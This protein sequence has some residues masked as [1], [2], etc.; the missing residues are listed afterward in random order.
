MFSLKFDHNAKFEDG[1]CDF[2]VL[3]A[4]QATSKS[5]N[6]MIK[7]KVRV[8][9]ERGLSAIVY[10]YLVGTINMQWK[11]EQFCKAVNHPEQWEQDVIT[12][13]FCVGKKG[14]CSVKIERNQH[15]ENPKITSY[16]VPDSVLAALKGIKVDS[17]IVDDSVPF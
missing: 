3:N 2:N 6:D 14:K 11:I 5:G 15:G 1:V 17:S 10:D 12:P 16:I 13:D 7:I 4:E 9:N 8:T